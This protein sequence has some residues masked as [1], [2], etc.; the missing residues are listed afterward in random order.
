[1]SDPVIK[2]RCLCGN[3]TYSADADPAAVVMCHCHDCQRQSG[4]PFSLNIVVDRAA[5]TIDGDSLKTYETVG[6]ESGEKRER[7]FCADCGS[8]MLSILAE[9]DDMAIIKA[10]TL[11]DASWVMPEMEVWCEERQPWL[12]NGEERGEFPRGLPT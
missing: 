11:D 3:I 8:T 4:A 7:M 6:E 10:G 12:E 2:G 1:M 5:F 9:A